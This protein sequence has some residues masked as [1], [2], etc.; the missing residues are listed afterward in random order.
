MFAVGVFYYAKAS[1]YFII[2]SIIIE[3]LTTKV[4]SLLGS[5]NKI[6]VCVL[7]NNG[8]GTETTRRPQ[9][10]KSVLILS[11]VVFAVRKPFTRRYL[12][13]EL[14]DSV[15]SLNKSDRY[16]YTVYFDIVS[17]VKR[18]MRSL[19]HPACQIKTIS[20]GG[21]R[22]REMA[23]ILRRWMSKGTRVHSFAVGEKILR[24]MY[25][26]EVNCPAQ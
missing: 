20:T 3:Q 8:G 14:A 9:N 16:S 10:T 22:Q 7:L 23:F 19:T 6:A 11:S 1:I 21:N 15:F 5:V 4:T 12:Y 13:V 2:F 24:R 17:K 26:Q 25:Y 18:Y